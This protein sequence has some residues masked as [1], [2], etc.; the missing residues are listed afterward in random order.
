METTC[1]TCWTRLS[2]AGARIKRV[3]CDEGG[4]QFKAPFKKY[5]IILDKNGGE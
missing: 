2:R 3:E 1:W 5:R 4:E